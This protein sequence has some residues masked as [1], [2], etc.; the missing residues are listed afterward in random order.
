MQEAERH[1]GKVAP[2]N[3]RE[4][5]SRRPPLRQPRKIALTSA[6]TS[7][8]YFTFVF[9]LSVCT[10]ASLTGE[11]SDLRGRPW[12]FVCV[13]TSCRYTFPLSM[14]TSGVACLSGFIYA[15][16]GPAAVPFTVPRYLWIP[17]PPYRAGGWEFTAQTVGSYYAY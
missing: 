9:T 15:H 5:L 13:T 12:H 14:R 7:A 16:N 6:D 1:M 4:S 3:D 2:C 17:L 11:I 10:R 8:W